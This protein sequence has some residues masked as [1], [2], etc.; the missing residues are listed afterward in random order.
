NVPSSKTAT[1]NVRKPDPA[2]RGAES[3]R[4][5][6]FLPQVRCKPQGPYLGTQGAAAWGPSKAPLTAEAARGTAERTRQAPAPGR[7]LDSPKDPRPAGRKHTR[8]ARIGSRRRG[9]DAGDPR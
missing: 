2:E 7:G 3:A 1:G 9:H 8:P 5:G 4:N 6:P